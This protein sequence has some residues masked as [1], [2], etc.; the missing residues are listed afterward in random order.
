MFLEV[1]EGVGLLGVVYG[2]QPILS[3]LLGASMGE[4]AVG[5]HGKCL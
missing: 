4:G 3:M 2:K 5:W 1:R